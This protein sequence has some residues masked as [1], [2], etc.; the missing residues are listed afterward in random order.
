MARILSVHA[1]DIVT[2]VPGTQTACTV[3]L[4]V[5]SQ[6]Y[7]GVQAPP[8]ILSIGTLPVAVTARSF[9]DI[10]AA[11]PA[12]PET[13][14]GGPAAHLMAAASRH[15]KQRLL[16]ARFE[17]Y[18]R[19]RRDVRAA[20]CREAGCG[21][22]GSAGSTPAVGEPPSV[23]IVRAACS[24]HAAA[25]AWPLESLVPE[26]YRLA[27]DAG[28]DARI[29]H[30][31]DVAA[32]LRD[33]AGSG[34]GGDGDTTA[35]FELRRDGERVPIPAG[36]P[37]KGGKAA[38]GASAAAAKKVSPPA[39]S[40]IKKGGDAAVTVKAEA[41]TGVDASSAAD[42]EPGGATA[43]ADA[44]GSDAKLSVKAE[45]SG[46]ADAAPDSTTAHGKPTQGTVPGSASQA[47]ELSLP[48]GLRGCDVVPALGPTR[49][50]DALAEV[51][52]CVHAVLPPFHERRR[53]ALAAAR[54][55]GGAAATAGNSGKAAAPAGD[56]GGKGNAAKT[57]A[58]AG[59]AGG[60][61]NATKA[62]APAGDAGGKGSAAKAAAPAGD[63]GGKGNAAKAAAPAG[64]AGGKGNA[65]KAAAPA[66]DAGGKGNATK[67]AAPAGDAGGKG[68]AA[69]AAVAVGDG[70]GK[71]N[72]GKASAAG[73]GG[74]KV[75]GTADSAAAAAKG[76]LLSQLP[77]DFRA[78]TGRFL[79]L[80]ALG[81]PN[82]ASMLDWEP[83][84]HVTDMRSSPDGP[85]CGRSGGMREGFAASGGGMF[86]PRHGEGM[87]RRACAMYVFSIPNFSIHPPSRTSSHQGLAHF[88]EQRF[89]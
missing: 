65:A 24:A 85:G 40:A 33:V 21:P 89:L 62:A 70:K 10:A 71:G 77:L 80:Q 9:L 83:F 46:D 81:L 66:G 60:N 54:G 43:V 20:A 44:D 64:D 37:S 14:A 76:Y 88:L 22:A 69:K 42:G 23:R 15:L 84:H 73:N 35:V 51:W 56:A 78:M 68:N 36:G 11:A 26:L 52:T 2:V 41:G 6:W 4:P 32:L 16:G 47:C 28:V 86:W 79:P 8:T 72:V 74:S 3:M 50:L 82:L 67:A 12:A 61:G 30:T 18:Q 49:D 57:A 17:L 59:D 1:G 27:A 34:G 58:P 48:P 13:P 25:L 87:K 29:V 39:G 75:A 55:S 63:A 19:A 45:P 5:P 31:F 7:G 38:S 53:V